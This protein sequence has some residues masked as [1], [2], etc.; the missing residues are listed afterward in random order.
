MLRKIRYYIN[1]CFAKELQHLRRIDYIVYYLCYRVLNSVKSNQ[2][3][4]LSESRESLSGNLKYIDDKIDKE[5]FDVVYSLKE[6]IIKKA[7]IIMQYV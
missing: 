4:I 1:W 7:V 6:N 5:K 3:L 2:I